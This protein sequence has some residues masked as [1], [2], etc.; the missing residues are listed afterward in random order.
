[1]EAW[2][3]DAGKVQHAACLRRLTMGL[4]N[5]RERTLDKASASILD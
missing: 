1:M 4:N 5:V 3:V 2:E